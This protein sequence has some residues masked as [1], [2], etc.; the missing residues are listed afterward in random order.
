MRILLLSD[1]VAEFG[2]AEE[3]VLKTRKLLEKKG[4]EVRI[5]GSDKRRI[6]SSFF[7]RWLSAKYY[8]QTRRL[9][10]SFKPDI[11]HCHNFTRNISPSPLLAAKRLEVPTVLTVHDFYLYCP[12]TCGIFSDGKVCER[13]Y[14]MLCPFYQCKTHKVGYQYV[15]YYLLKWLKAGMHRYIIRKNVDYFICP[16]EALKRLITRSLGVED[17]R[18]IHL[19]N[20]IETKNKR[21]AFDKTNEKLF[22]FVG[23]LSREK[24]VDVGIRA[25]DYL[26]KKEGLRNIKLKIIGDGPEMENL[27]RQV[28]KLGLDKNI[29]FI[30]QVE[31]KGLGRYYQESCAVLLP[32]VY[33]ENAPLVALEAMLSGKPIIASDIGGLPELVEHN[34]TGY[35][36]EMSNYVE[37]GEYMKRLYDNRE[38]SAKLG[39]AGFE[40][41]RRE[42]NAQSHYKRLMEIYDGLIS[43]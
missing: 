1:Y 3:V 42:F 35:L 34:K 33:L 4:H 8:R 43:G 32:S 7:S 38:L 11:V 39:K 21:I 10:K 22:L 9:I 5:I 37:M 24:G 40:K 16:T 31:N 18:V 23:R 13:G 15:P 27:V 36:F 20:F 41:C 17:S 29:K 26:I 12:K 19:P 28:T 25:M 30:G 6:L 14:N 2:G